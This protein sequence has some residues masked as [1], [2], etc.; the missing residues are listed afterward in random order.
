MRFA[1]AEPFLSVIGGGLAAALLT[2]IFNVYWDLR[3]QKQAE[4]WEFRRYQANQIHFAAFGLI[5][6][7]FAAKTELY[8]LCCTLETLLGVLTQLAAQADAIVRQ[9]GGPQLTRRPV[10]TEKDGAVTAIPKIQPGAS[11]P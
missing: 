1:L 5:E 8:F 7:F 3:K 6:V 2:F 10:R 11:N 9:Q 4:D